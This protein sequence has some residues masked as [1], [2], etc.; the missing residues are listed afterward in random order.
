MDYLTATVL[1]S[2]IPEVDCKPSNGV[3][4]LYWYF[5]WFTVL[6]NVQWWL[7][8]KTRYF[9]ISTTLTSTLVLSVAE[10]GATVLHTISPSHLHRR[11]ALPTH[12]FESPRLF[13]FPSR[14]HAL[15][16][17]PPTAKATQGLHRLPLAFQLSVPA[18]SCHHARYSTLL[19]HPSQATLITHAI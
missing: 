14:H 15:P 6:P 10:V 3:R 9:C 16:S 8:N 5:H 12:S 2:I 18:T 11:H 1:V 7:Y 4:Y 13:P 17:L 19:G